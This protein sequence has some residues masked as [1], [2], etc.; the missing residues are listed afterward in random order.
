MDLRTSSYIEVSQAV[1]NQAYFSIGAVLNSPGWNLTIPWIYLFHCHYFFTRKCSLWKALLGIWLSRAGKFRT[2]KV[3]TDSGSIDRFAAFLTQ[4]CFISRKKFQ[5][6]FTSLLTSFL[7]SFYFCF[8]L[9]TTQASKLYCTLLFTI[10]NSQF[11]FLD[12]IM[13]FSEITDNSN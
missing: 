10:F 4:M 8:C 11:V 1:Y 7:I 13:N 2:M 5:V 3:N 12:M 9:R 6:L